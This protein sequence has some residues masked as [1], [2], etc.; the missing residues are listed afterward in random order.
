MSYQIK[1][2]MWYNILMVKRGLILGGVLA[3]IS[4]ASFSYVYADTTGSTKFSV[5]VE[6]T[7]L[8]LTIPATPAV[9]DLNPTMTGASFG[10][11]NIN[12]KVAT[13]NITGYQLTM[14]PTNSQ[15]NTSLIRTELVGT[16]QTYREIETL[17]LTDPVST[18]YPEADFTANKWGYK[19]T[20]DNYYGIDPN[21]TTVSH[22]AWITNEPTNGTNHNLTLAAKVDASTVSGAYETTLNFHAVTNAVVAKD[23]VTFNGNGA[24]SES[25]DDTFVLVSGESTTLPT[26]T[27]T[28]PGYAF[29]GWNTAQNGSGMSYAD[30][31]AYTAVST[32]YSHDITLY[33]MWMDT[34]SG[35][36]NKLHPGGS[37]LSGGITISRAYEI[38][39][40]N[41]GKGM[42]ERDEGD[43]DNDGDTSEY[44]QVTDGVYHT[45][46]VRW[47]MQGMTPEI[48]NSVEVMED[49][50]RALDVRDWKLYHITKLRDGRCWMTQN[51]DLDLST[52][53]TL[54]NT[55]TDLNSKPS[56]TPGANMKHFTGDGNPGGSAN[57]TTPYSADPGD[58][59]L[60]PTNVPGENDRIFFDLEECKTAS[61]IQ[62]YTI[63]EHFYSGNYYNYS[64]S[65]ASNDT[66][67]YSGNAPDSICPKGWRLPIER[68]VKSLVPITDANAGEYEKL[69][70][71]S[72][73]TE[74]YNSDTYTSNG[75]ALLGSTPLYFAR[76]GR[77][78]GGLMGWRQ[79][80]AGYRTATLSAYDDSDAIILSFDRKAN[81]VSHSGGLIRHSSLPVRCI[82]R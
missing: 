44:Y 22:P 80:E 23:T 70:K 11:T 6:N 41:A 71:K 53:I 28:K 20:G 65:V 49:D 69:L 2:A 17:D 7:V 67:T 52:S 46:D 29:L 54:T 38:A 27:F 32:D 40:T 37:G 63:C 26:N 3:I 39:Y 30:E 68:G 77:I 16:E 18:G 51:L 45:Y 58:V 75:F 24:D 60:L 8:E 12:V 10:S 73:V 48:C 19:I 61:G 15:T 1:R 42:W 76:Y 74:N 79:S 13:N 56:W 5:D 64:A 21:N 62:E 57:N 43:R 59:W 14:T 25:M 4:L 82:A 50:Y 66:S 78:Y 33:A 55:T 9:I 34:S 47:D 81:S 31:G 35:I 36:Y 72:G